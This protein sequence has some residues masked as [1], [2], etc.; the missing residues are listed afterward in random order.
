MLDGLRKMFDGHGQ[1][2]FW[3]GARSIRQI[4]RYL[5]TIERRSHTMAVIERERYVRDI[6]ADRRYDTPG[7][8]IRQG[9]KVC[10]QNDEDG[11]I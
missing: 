1:K 11:I 10:S 3:N 9:F 6:L 2:P 7:R 8:I 4:I 5:E